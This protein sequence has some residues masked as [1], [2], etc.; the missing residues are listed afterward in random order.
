MEDVV[1]LPLLRPVTMVAACRRLARSAVAGALL[2]TGMSAASWA[3]A[4]KTQVADLRYGV[5]LY[6][7]YQQDYLGALSEL[8]VAD[9]RDGIQGHGDN[10]EIFVGGISLAFGMEKRAEAIFN[11]LLQDARHPQSV[12]DAAWFYLGKLHYL[13]G[14]WLEAQQSFARVSDNFNPLLAAELQALQINLQIHLEPVESLSAQASLSETQM[15]ALR[16]W[17]P[18]A[19]YN[20]GAAS[21]RRNDFEQARGYWQALKDVAPKA[22]AREAEY[23]A[24]QDKT[25]TAIGYSYLTQKSYIGAIEAFTQVNLNASAANQ[26]LLGYG[27]AALAQEEYTRA[28]KPWQL[29]RQR[30][31]QDPAVQESLLALPFAYEKLDAQGEALTAYEEAETLLNAELNVIAQLRSSL[32]PAEL[33]M[34]VDDQPQAATAQ[35]N[36]PLVKINN[37]QGQN[38]L[39]LDKTSVIDTRSAYLL[40]LFADNK[41]QTA[42]QE[43]RDLLRLRELLQAWQPKLHIYHQLLIDKQ[44]LRQGPEQQLAR[45]ALAEQLQ[46]LRDTRQQL[47][48]RLATIKANQDY[49]A[50]ADDPTRALYRRV[51]DARAALHRLQA[52]GE[53]TAEYRE[54]LR[55]YRGIL[56]WRAAQAFPHKLWQSEK[57][58]TAIN[59]T[60]T[61]MTEASARVDSVSATHKDIRPALA[62]IERLQTQVEEQ[63]TQVNAAINARSA[64]LGVQVDQHL[65]R[66]QRRLN[67][68]LAQAHLAVARL[69]DAALRKS[70]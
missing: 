53:D 9:A 1:A 47:D 28:L 43:L 24:L 14:H 64:A 3:E 45:Q 16:H 54:R 68:Y 44:T 60:L 15:D 30:S 11:E 48:K 40:E 10:P 65:E 51:E 26:A 34:R 27:W 8:M 35:D 20:L 63:L 13:R 33:L 23:R 29:L 18:Y 66:H 36:R 42:I 21:A 32:T 2:L 22:M 49:L 67:A 46:A 4:P 62:N 50:L 12:R 19:L 25:Y 38:W 39:K 56:L 69:Y 37:E 5:A 61:Q 58:R 17:A 52:A 59:Q 6:H 41:F 55:I 31:L 57:S 7:Y 70:Q